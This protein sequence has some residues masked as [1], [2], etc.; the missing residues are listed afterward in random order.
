[1]RSLV[2]IRRAVLLVVVV[3]LFDSAAFGQPWDGNGVEGDP[4]LIY[5]ACDMQAI[6]ADANYWDA[7]FVLMADIDLSAYTG[8][9]F[10]IIGNS[11]NRFTGVFDGNGHRI[12]NFTYDSNVVNYIGLFWY[13]D[14]PNSE[15]KNL[16]LIDPNIDG[17]GGT[18]SSSVVRLENGTVTDCYVEGG[19]ISGLGDAGGLVGS[20]GLGGPTATVSNCHASVNV[21][22]G[23]VGGLV[24]SNHEATI[25]NC[26]STGS[27]SGDDWVGGLVGTNWYGGTIANCHSTCEVSGDGYVGGLVGDNDNSAHI[28]NSSA[29]GNVTGTGHFIGGL[30]GANHGDGTI[31]GCYAG[32]DVSGKYYVGGLVG[33][34]TSDILNSYANGSILG[35]YD[36]GGLVGENWNGT[37]S[38]CYSA[39]SVSGNYN[40]GGLV[41]YDDG[42]VYTKCFWDNTVNPSL[43]GIGNGSNPEVIGES[44]TNMQ[45]A[46]TFAGWGC[47]PVWTID[48]GNDYP[49]LWWE[50]TPGEVL[51][52]QWY[53]G[54]SGE[55][56]DPYLIET[57]EQLNNI[58]RIPCDWDNHFQLTVDIDLASYTGTSFN[59]IGRYVG[60]DDPNNKPF[61]GVFDGDGHIISN[62]TYTYNPPTWYYGLGLF[63]YVDGSDA[64]IK[65]VGMT[66]PNVDVGSGLDVG[67][68]VGWLKYGTVRDCYVEGGSV[69]G[70]QHV[71]GLVGAS[72]GDIFRCYSTASV[73]CGSYNCGGLA[74]L[75]VKGKITSCYSSG[76]VSGNCRVGGLVGWNPG[77]GWIG[78][79]A[80]ISSCYA[81][82]S[83]WGD[84]DYIGGLVGAGSANVVIGSFWDTQTS[85][86][87]T[88]AGGT[89]KTTAQM[90]DINT[91]LAAG[92]DFVG[93]VIDG[94]NDIW[95]ICE[96]TNYPKFVWQIPAADFGCPDGVNF[97]DY[98]FFA[99]HWLQ[100]I[101][102]ECGGVE[103]TGEGKVNWVD[104]ALFAEY[105]MLTDCGECGGADFTGDENVDLADLY[106]FATYWLG[107][108]YAEVDLTNDGQVGL[109][110]L[111]EFTENWLEGM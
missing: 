60:T 52:N 100:T 2:N 19:R 111:R 13:V 48:D 92:W 89:P 61:T 4:Y 14:D 23:S 16:G 59:I 93:E 33:T 106:V 21:S 25:S 40:I 45:M 31:S 34:N 18:V 15:I 50:N 29:T 57:A 75:T 49:R 105:W 79:P 104:F 17:P 88:S 44:T 95:D 62:F 97:I 28:S 102:G 76:D 103:L 35:G 86:Q 24:G 1:M 64:E 90:Q 26:Y 9:S 78:G 56:N 38:N 94:P 109:D 42:G 98:A 58:G 30:V 108:E 8:T 72:W 53:A 85:G 12:Y 41:G 91:F 6:G 107:F 37:I 51:S 63:S 32:G 101:Y 7:H 77:G 27:V 22:G 71:G 82:G 67:S 110:D 96:G 11:V 74:G 39:G 10:N 80:T 47:E 43:T 87:T 46:V 70:D 65:N 54:G 5:D 81:T 73:M 20:L 69:S 36:V 66:D 68:L 55:P 99:T 83:V 3:C 84:N